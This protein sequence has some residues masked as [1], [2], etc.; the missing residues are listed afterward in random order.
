MMRDE[1]NGVSY[2]ENLRFRSPAEVEAD[3]ARAASLDAPAPP[4]GPPRPVEEPS[5][6][7]FV[8]RD[9]DW[10]SVG[11]TAF[12][13]AADIGDSAFAFA[14]GFGRGVVDMA[15]GAVLGAVELADLNAKLS[16]GMPGER[17]EA[18]QALWGMGGAIVD[19]TLES[20]RYLVHGVTNPGD[21][22]DAMAQLGIKGSA[23]Q[24]G[25][26]TAS[27]E[28]TVTSLY[29]MAGPV[30]SLGRRIVS[31]TDDAAE[32]AGRTSAGAAGETIGSKSGETVHT[33]SGKST[34]RQLADERRAAGEFDLVNEPIRDAQGRPIDVPTRVDLKTGAP[35]AAKGTQTAWP[36]AV[37]FERDLILDDKPLARAIS[38]D[39]Q[40]I[41]RFISAYQQRTGRMPRYIAITLYDSS[42]VPIRTD[43]YRPEIFLP[44]G[45]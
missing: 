3:F 39:R 42:G 19:H 6:L 15:T 21:V 29:G 9:F 20:G 2:F 45:K 37:K 38:R 26:A 10:R 12:N 24:L 35:V 16:Y 27:A 1:V 25:R 34:H 11:N 22:L 33:R 23:E 31:G 8:W 44:E 30:R 28:G 43:L 7:D 41:I 14:Q 40:Q 4:G 36:D 32:A 13:A 18:L 5:V 17:L